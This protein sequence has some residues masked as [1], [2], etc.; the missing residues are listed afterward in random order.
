MPDIISAIESLVEQSLVR[1]VDTDGAPRL[2]M[3]ETVR[4]FAVERLAEWGEQDVRRRHATYVLGLATRAERTYSS[5]EPGDWQATIDAERG[6][7]RA[8]LTW[9]HAHGET[10][11]ALAVASAMF[12]PLWVNGPQALEQGQWIRRGLAMPGGSPATRVTAL[13]NGAWTDQVRQ[14]FAAGRELAEEALVVAERDGN[15]FGIAC[16][17]TSLGT[18]AFWTGDFADAQRWLQAALA[19]FRRLGA[20]GRIGWTLNHLAW[21]DGRDAVDEGGDPAALALAHFEE[22]LVHFR[23]IDDR[24]GAARTQHGIAFFTSKQGDFTRALACSRDVLAFDWSQRWPVYHHLENIADIAGRTGRPEVAARLYAAAVGQ[25]DRLGRPIETVFRAEHERDVAISR[26]ALG[27][28]AFAAAFAAGRSLTLEQAV[29]EAL[30]FTIA[31]PVSSTLKLPPRAS[32]ILPLLASGMSNAEI[33]AALFL[34]ERT[35]E[36]HVA[37]LFKILGVHS[38]AAAIEAA[39]AAG[40]L[41]E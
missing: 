3:L 19:G 17:S 6:N 20:R 9:A 38:R 1:V 35:V 11:T 29:E 15:V 31:K 25:R 24:R 27:E 18:L 37:S 5:D 13:L 40:L 8:V 7:L 39:T 23:A 22:A 2:V 26:T 30:G 12:D 34:S 33:A 28:A 41:G 14:D 4:E 16:A 32:E 21:L 10:D 36:S